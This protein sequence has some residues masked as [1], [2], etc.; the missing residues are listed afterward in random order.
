LDLSGLHKDFVDGT[1]S[2]NCNFSYTINGKQF[3]KL[4]VTPVN[5]IYPKLSLFVKTLS[6]PVDK[7]QA[8]YAKWQEKTRKDVE[9]SF[10]ILQSKFRILTQK[11]E[12]WSI[13]D[14]NF[15]G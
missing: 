6:Q 12:L 10:G 1:Y 9:C 5:G 2:E 3:D 13:K 15:V 14:I 4:W 11:V 7:K 8:N